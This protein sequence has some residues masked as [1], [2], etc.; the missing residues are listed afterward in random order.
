MRTA[1]APETLTPDIE[2]MVSKP[3]I[4]P[5]PSTV[6]VFST[7]LELCFGLH[8]SYVEPLQCPT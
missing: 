4:L 2:P 8:D 6:N 7:T 1:L 5:G 3:A